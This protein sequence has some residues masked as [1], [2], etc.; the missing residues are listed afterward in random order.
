MAEEESG[1][2]E[3]REDGLSEK[4]V[5]AAGDVTAPAAID[6]ADLKLSLGADEAKPRAPGQAKLLEDLKAKSLLARAQEA[7]KSPDAAVDVE[8]INKG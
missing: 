4:P 8:V 5:D 6:K 3:S 1:E 7:R 2:G